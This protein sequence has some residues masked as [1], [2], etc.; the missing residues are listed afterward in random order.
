MKSNYELRMELI[1]RRLEWT[2]IMI[3]PYETKSS[4]KHAKKRIKEI[5]KVLKKL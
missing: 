4:K 2:E 3:D 1:K 5:D